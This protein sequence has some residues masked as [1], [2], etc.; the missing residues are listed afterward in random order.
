MPRVGKRHF[1][2]TKKGMQQAKEYA[3]KTGKPLRVSKGK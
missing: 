3:R 2:Y 1:P